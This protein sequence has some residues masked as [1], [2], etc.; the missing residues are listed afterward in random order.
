M[1]HDDTPPDFSWIVPKDSDL[2]RRLA[3]FTP[4]GLQA[5]RNE[6]ERAYGVAVSIDERDEEADELHGV[7]SSFARFDVSFRLQRLWHIRALE[8]LAYEI[9]SPPPAAPE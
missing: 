8:H 6:F 2:G 9:G 1:P 3:S 4:F 7:W 5:L